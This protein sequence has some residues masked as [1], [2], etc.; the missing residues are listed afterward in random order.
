MDQVY[1]PF[2]TYITGQKPVYH[3]TAAC[4][5]V[6]RASGNDSLGIETTR[7]PIR[8]PL[9]LAAPGLCFVKADAEYTLNIWV[10]WLSAKKLVFLVQT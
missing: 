2:K 5:V 10:L 1:N 6:W 9:F 7:Q 8:E 4:P 3:G